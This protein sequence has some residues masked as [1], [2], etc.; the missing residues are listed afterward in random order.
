MD[1]E[2]FFQSC[3]S[4]GV[5]AFLLCR[6]EKE[7]KALRQAIETLR[8]CPNCRLSPWQIDVDLSDEESRNEIPR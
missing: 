1:I 6:M 8:H 7:L 3:F 4:V 5:A 2:S